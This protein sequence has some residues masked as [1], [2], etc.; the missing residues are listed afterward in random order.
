MGKLK[1]A[2]TVGA[3]VVGG[4]RTHGGRLE[5]FVPEIS[6]GGCG[7]PGSSYKEFIFPGQGGREGDRTEIERDEGDGMV[8]EDGWTEEG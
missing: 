3:G 7:Q 4:D 2:A 1:T 8:G 5:T 6:C